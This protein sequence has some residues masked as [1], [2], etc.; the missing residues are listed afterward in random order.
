MGVPNSEVGYTLAT[1]GKGDHEV[2]HGHVVAKKAAHS[3]GIPV[4]VSLVALV[5]LGRYQGQFVHHI[6]QA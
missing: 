2:H 3:E 1:T 6:S 4:M 5:A